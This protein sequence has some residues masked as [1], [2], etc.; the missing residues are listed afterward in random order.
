MFTPVVRAGVSL[1]PPPAHVSVER[2][3]ALAAIAGV[4]ILQ[5]VEAKSLVL[6]C[7]NCS[8]S[9]LILA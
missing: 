1:H 3:V 2:E 4:L 8:L 7:S 5:D 9:I 6:Q